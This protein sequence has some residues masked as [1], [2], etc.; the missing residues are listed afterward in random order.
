[1]S[2][3][4]ARLAAAT[5]LARTPAVTPA[6]SRSTANGVTTVS[7]SGNIA[8][9]FGMNADD[10]LQLFLTQLQNQDPTEP[11]N[12]KEMLTQL[13]QFTMISSL[14]KLDKALGGTQLA[15]ASALIGDQVIGTDTKGLPAS[16]VVDRIVQDSSGVLLVLEGGAIVA[17][18]DVTQVLSGPKSTSAPSSATT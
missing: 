13:A 4:I 2:I 15:Q 8:D 12:N 10:F 16:G 14:E 6:A 5:G 1:M 9:A 7:N 11:M 18:E 17:T 3:D